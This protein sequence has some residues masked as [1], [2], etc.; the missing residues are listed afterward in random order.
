SSRSGRARTQRCSSRVRPRTSCEVSWSASPSPPPTAPASPSPPLEGA[1]PVTIHR[2]VPEGMA[3]LA[4]V[5]TTASGK[6]AL[7]MEL[8]RRRGD[9]E[10]VSVDSMQVYRGMDIGTAKPTPEEQAEV[11]HHMI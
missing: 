6:S 8:A 1:A 5:G 9:V 11:R 7:A 4:I 10:L 3:P 2:V